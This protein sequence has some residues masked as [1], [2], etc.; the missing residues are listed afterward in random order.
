M[1]SARDAWRSV[2]AGDVTMSNKDRVGHTPKRKPV[3][4]AAEKRQAKREKRE[5]LKTSSKRR[6]RQAA[7]HHRTTH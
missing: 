4:T 3:R 6:K 7:A 1:A 5:E 2:A